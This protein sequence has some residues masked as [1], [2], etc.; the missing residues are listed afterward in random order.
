MHD[1]LLH[2]SNSSVDK[3]FVCHNATEK[4]VSFVPNLDL[5]VNL[6][7]VFGLLEEAEVPLDKPRRSWTNLE[8]KLREHKGP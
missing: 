7:R 6:V 2:T 1:P 3:V 8:F 5:L 4:H